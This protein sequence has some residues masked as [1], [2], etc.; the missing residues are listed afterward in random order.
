M[1]EPVRTTWARQSRRSQLLATS[2]RHTVKPTLLA[3]S[4]L[5]GFI[6]PSRIVDHAAGLLPPPDGTTIERVGLA[7]CGAEWIK[8]PEVE[9][10]EERAILYLH[11]GALVTCS[12]A[13]HRRM[14]SYISHSTRAP[15]LNVD[16]RMMPEVTIEHMVAD[17]LSGYRWLLAQGYRGDNIT[18]IGDS[19][20][21]FLAF[22]TALAIRD[23]ELEAPAGIA[24]MSPLLDLGVARKEASPYSDR[25]DVF[26][27]RACRGLERFTA[28]VDARHEVTAPR[29]SPIDAD[30]TGLP[31]V[32]IQ[33][34]SHE[35]LR[36]ECEEMVDR[37]AAADVAAE[38]QVWK[39]QVH[40]FQAAGSFLPEG[41]S[42]V[43]EIGS[44]VRGLGSPRAVAS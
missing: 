1:D 19:A 44:F 3:W 13:T 37:L 27:V 9:G 28:D 33:V 17:C 34:G 11:G 5:P 36:P 39:G 16:F 21:G 24:C 15:A 25:C 43:R 23:E 22:L 12:L 8:G 14:V 38:L 20:G 4:F 2:L 42:A 30:L 18:I 10:D 31:P 41:R 26:T 29:I 35:I 7:Q 32:L 40:V 6:W